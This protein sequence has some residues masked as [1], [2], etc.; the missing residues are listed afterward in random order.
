[1]GRRINQDIK[2]RTEKDLVKDLQ[3]FTYERFYV[4]SSTDQKNICVNYCKSKDL[5]VI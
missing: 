4:W 3:V 1:M 5:L 2:T